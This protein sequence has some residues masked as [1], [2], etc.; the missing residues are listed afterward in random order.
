MLVS[1][2][3]I[4]YFPYKITAI[5]HAFL[6]F[7]LFVAGVPAISAVIDADVTAIAGAYCCWRLLCPTQSLHRFKKDSEATKLL[8]YSNK[9]GFEATQSLPKNSL[10]ASK[11]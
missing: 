1:T 2:A 11:K 5:V 4:W 6:N 10:R 3:N 7:I 8:H 9:K